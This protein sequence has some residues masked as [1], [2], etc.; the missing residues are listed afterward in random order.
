MTWWQPALGLDVLMPRCWHCTIKRTVAWDYMLAA[1][2]LLLYCFE[3][4]VFCSLHYSLFGLLLAS[5]VWWLS[6]SYLWEPAMLLPSGLSCFLLKRASV[7]L[8]WRFTSQGV[9]LASIPHCQLRDHISPTHKRI[10]THFGPCIHCS[11]SVL[12]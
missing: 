4:A 12:I 11:S 3:T 7:L 5:I 9:W 6:W 8:H 2:C 10:R 1:G